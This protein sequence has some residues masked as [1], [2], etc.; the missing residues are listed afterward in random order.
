MQRGLLQAAPALSLAFT[1][2]AWPRLPA[3]GAVLWS[4]S[5]LAYCCRQLGHRGPA[6]IRVFT[7]IVCLLAPAWGATLWSRSRLAYP[8]RCAKAVSPLALSGNRREWLL[9]NVSKASI[10]QALSG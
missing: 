6:L 3:W 7:F 4:H 9:A 5:R 2:M 1:C 8:S 10:F